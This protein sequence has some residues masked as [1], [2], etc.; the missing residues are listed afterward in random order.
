MYSYRT[1]LL[2]L[3]LAQLMACQSVS[4]SN[5]EPEGADQSPTKALVVTEHFYDAKG[6]DCDQPDSLQMNCA[7]ID[8][9]FPRV[10][11][12]AG[13]I[14]ELVERQVYAYLAAIVSGGAPLQDSTSL[15]E[16]AELFW[17]YREE[18][19]G[20]AVYNYFTAE[21]SYEVLFNESSYLTIEI[22]SYTYQ[23][24]A[25]GSPTTFVQTYHLDSG[26]ALRLQDLVKDLAALRSIAQQK[27][28]Q[29]RK[30]AFEQGFEFDDIFTFDLPANFGLTKDG[31][32]CHYVAYEVGPYALGGTQF[33][34]PFSDL[35]GILQAPF[36]DW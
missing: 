2:L 11:T 13:L 17:T 24:G 31:I 22:D 15:Q 4:S 21:S 26:L 23:G 1:V 8:L 32:Y 9:E 35:Q 27:F 30:E 5:N 10:Q 16:A 28:R 12:K 29:E 19:Q 25:H 34:I 3:G 18:M 7:R 6:E 14:D 20:S 36:V 33:V